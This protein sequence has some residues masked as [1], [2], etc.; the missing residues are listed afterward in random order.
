[1]ELPFIAGLGR[2]TS[3]LAVGG[4]AFFVGA[5]LFGSALRFRCDPVT[6][7]INRVVHVAPNFHEGDK[8]AGL[9]F[10]TFSL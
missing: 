5:H 1:M 10:P 4:P 6:Q 9:E 2:R 8:P 3:S 7:L